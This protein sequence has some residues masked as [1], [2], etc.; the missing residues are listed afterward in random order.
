MLSKLS[1]ILP[2]KCRAEASR[3]HHL[4]LVQLL[5]SPLT[6]PL[7]SM[8][9]KDAAVFSFLEDKANYICLLKKQNLCKF[10]EQNT[11]FLKTFSSKSW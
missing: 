8:L 6:P 9:H 5:S 11:H 2:L 10:H 4:S 3:G 7:E 1:R